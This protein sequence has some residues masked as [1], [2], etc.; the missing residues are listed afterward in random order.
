MAYVTPEQTAGWQTLPS[1]RDAA[2]EDL[3][4]F[5]N[6]EKTVV[7]FLQCGSCGES[8]E[9]VKD[10]LGEAGTSQSSLCQTSCTGYRFPEAKGGKTGCSYQL[11][12]EAESHLP[13]LPCLISKKDAILCQK[14]RWISFLFTFN[15]FSEEQTMGQASFHP[16][17]AYKT[18]L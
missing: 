6:I 3:T 13:L 14:T 7:V 18:N 2:G 15:I 4:I 8:P 16:D 9:Q 1:D 17:I 12:S 10:L 5:K 11:A